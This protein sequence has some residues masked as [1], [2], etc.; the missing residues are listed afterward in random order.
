MR[1]LL[2]SMFPFL[3]YVTVASVCVHVFHVFKCTMYSV[4]VVRPSGLCPRG[5]AYSVS[6]SVLFNLPKNAVFTHS[7]LMRA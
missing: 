1:V 2:L 3:L 6:D 4:R 5:F 7:M